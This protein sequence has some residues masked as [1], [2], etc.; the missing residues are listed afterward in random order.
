M[1]EEIKEILD[2]MFH[3]IMKYEEDF[4]DLEENEIRYQL[5]YNKMQKLYDY[6]TNLQQEKPHLH[7]NTEWEDLLDYKGRTYIELDRFKQVQQENERLEENNSNMQE[8]MARVWEENERLKKENNNK[9]MNDYAHAIDESWYRE[10]Y[11]DYKSRCEKVSQVIDEMLIYD[12]F[13]DTTRAFGNAAR[14]LK[15]YLSDCDTLEEFDKLQNGS[16]KDEYK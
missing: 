13:S 8:E 6:I 12:E 14:E 7:T 4:E 5:P 9:A 11:D 15:F 2:N 16:E 1:N 3:I 10:L